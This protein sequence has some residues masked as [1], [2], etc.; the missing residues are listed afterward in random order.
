MSQSFRSFVRGVDSRRTSSALAHHRSFTCRPLNDRA[1]TL[2]EL[3]VVIAIIAILAGLLLPALA[4]AK[5]KERHTACINNLKQIG[6]A[7]HLYVEDNDDTF[8]GAAAASPSKAVL[9]D[10]IYWNY[11]DPVASL[12]GPNR[13]DPLKSPIGKYIGGFN[14]TLL[15]CPSAKEAL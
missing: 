10:W 1:F 9:E 13:T 4:K 7:F 15:R 3:L 6:L 5:E 12:V 14:Q 11:A 8:P 2:I